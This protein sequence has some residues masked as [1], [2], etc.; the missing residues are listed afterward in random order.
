M[1]NPILV[2]GPARSGTSMI[3]QILHVCGAWK[4]DTVPPDPKS[5]PDG[6]FENV[7]LREKVTKEILR[8]NG[9]DPLGVNDLPEPGSLQY[10]SF[11]GE[12]MHAIEEQGYEGGPWFYKDAKLCY[13]PELWMREFPGARWVLTHREPNAI[14]S[15]CLQT[16][17]MRQHSGDPVFWAAWVE[18]T[19]KRLH[20]LSE[21]YN[22]IVIDT[23]RVAKDRDFSHI[24]AAVEEL[25]LT[26]D[27]EAVEKVVKP[28]YWRRK[29]V[30]TSI[31]INTS[32][33]KINENVDSACKR[34]LPWLGMAPPHTGEIAIVGG[35]PSIKTNWKEIRKLQNKGTYILA[36]NGAY[37][38][39]R[40]KNII[41]DGMAMM[42]ARKDLNL[43]F[44]TNPS[45]KTTFFVSS[46][47]DPEVFDRLD[48]NNV[49][50]V[51]VWH[52]DVGAQT[53]DIATCYRAGYD[54]II[55]TLGTTIGIR[56]LWLARALGFRKYHIFGL[57]SCLRGDEHHAYEQKQNDDQPVV[58]MNINGQEFKTHIWM[59]AQVQDF[60]MWAEKFRDTGW[61]I[62]DCPPLQALLEGPPQQRE[63][64]NGPRVESGERQLSS[65]LA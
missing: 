33:E 57:D 56:A 49:Y 35:G 42:D 16:H 59:G 7:Y 41:A 21:K 34:D 63:T 10:P 25:G 15:S 65:L 48:Q 53:A 36:L 11:K 61:K 54:V 24:K 50:N 23:D 17:F 51:V 55:P 62:H 13:M 40:S 9:C 12:V 58:T 60:K 19:F 31:P 32:Y 4:G 20:S 3:A 38:F 47:V 5:N 43:T 27:Q 46:Q 52:N 26:W 39:L 37:N 22:A 45:V 14:I 30:N 64:N 1:T 6:F 44:V 28:Q 2:S 8:A 18:E 29:D